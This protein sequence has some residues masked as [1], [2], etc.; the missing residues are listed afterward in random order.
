MNKFIIY[1][2]RF[3]DGGISEGRTIYQCFDESEAEALFYADHNPVFWK[4]IT[5]EVK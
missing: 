4:I 3:I 1:Y 2:E 5:I